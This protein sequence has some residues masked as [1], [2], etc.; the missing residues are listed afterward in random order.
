MKCPRCH[1]TMNKDYDT[2]TATC[3]MCGKVKHY[4]TNADKKESQRLE[5]EAIMSFLKE[6]WATFWENITTIVSTIVVL[7]IF[8][9]LV[10]NK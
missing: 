6:C 5:D 1:V 2:R 4:R 10:F 7:I 9:L 3:P 8:I